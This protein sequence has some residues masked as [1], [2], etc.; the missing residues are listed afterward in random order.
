[1]PRKLFGAAA[2]AHKKAQAKKKRAAAHKKGATKKHATKKHATKK[3]A[4]AKRVASSTHHAASFLRGYHDGHGDVRAKRPLRKIRAGAKDAYSR[5][6]RAG[7]RE[8][9]A[10][11]RSR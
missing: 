6:Y 8:A 1:M 9:R 4:G 5:G 3:R 2:A 10:E 7:T 11:H